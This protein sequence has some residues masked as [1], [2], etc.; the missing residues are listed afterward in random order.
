[1][2]SGG[3]HGKQSAILALCQSSEVLILHQVPQAT[4][5]GLDFAEGKE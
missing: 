2:S 1:M 4:L 3:E 5:L